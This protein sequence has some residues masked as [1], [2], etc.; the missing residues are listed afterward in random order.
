[1]PEGMFMFLARRVL[2]C[3]LPLLMLMGIICGISPKYA[4]PRQ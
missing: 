1:M 3:L 4:Q 2:Y